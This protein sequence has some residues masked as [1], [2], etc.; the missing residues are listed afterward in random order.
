MGRVLSM[1][2]RKGGCG[3]TTSSVSISAA[4]A[5]R[6]NRVLLV[7]LDPQAHST[8]SFGYQTTESDNDLCAVLLNG[9]SIK[10]MIK[11]TYLKNLHL[12]PGSKTLIDF[13]KHNYQKT[14]ARTLLAEKLNSLVGKYDYILFD[15]P[16]AFSLLTVSA[17]IASSEVYVP[18]QTHYLNF[19]GLADIVKL[20]YSINSLYNPM[21]KL[22]GIIPTFF[23]QRTRLA[24]TI[25]TKI[26]EN[27]GPEIIMH[28]V[29]VNIAL[30]EAPGYG[31]T[32]FQY[33]LK[34]IGAYDYLRLADQID[35]R[36]KG[37]YS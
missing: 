30:A 2:N 1:C 9:I 28:P 32:I 31:K 4:L 17:L 14:Q 6:G 15:T 34:S 33:K 27:L 18:M 12:I 5:L 16:P 8:L 26:K 3:K 13:E 23:K 36:E 11:R 22:K 19:E 25:M 10:D 29:R 21:L 35:N 20:I 7:D 24:G 37:M